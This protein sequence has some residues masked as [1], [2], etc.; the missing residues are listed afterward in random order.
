MLPGILSILSGLSSRPIVTYQSSTS[1]TA[2][3]SSYTFSGQ[4]IGSAAQD[5][6]VVAIITAQKS[7][8]TAIPTLNS[9]TIGGSSA[10]VHATGG[11]SESAGGNSTSWGVASLLMSTGTTSD[12]V[13]NLAATAT[14][15]MCSVFT[16]TGYVSALPTIYTANNADPLL[17]AI[18]NFPSG[19]ALGA[20][21]FLNG[22]AGATTVTSS[23]IVQPV[24][25]VDTDVES[26]LRTVFSLSDASGLPTV[27][28]N[29]SGS[30]NDE[31]G[32]CA[33]W[34]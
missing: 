7:D 15:A 23:G 5:R 18:G 11:E 16:V 29:P 9:C 6:L 17:F 22:T 10:T 21:V 31:S 28:V 14:A 34:Q 3:S 25:H 19:A 32:F 4:S 2:G 27:T 12:V 24:T 20:C 30:V 8:S 33:V 13:F 26:R 1:T